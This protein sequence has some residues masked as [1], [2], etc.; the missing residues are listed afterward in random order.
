MVKV[1]ES[2]LVLSPPEP[3]WPTIQAIREKHDR[4]FSRWMPHITLLYPFYP[5]SHFESA[6]EMLADACQQVHPFEVSFSEFQAFQHGRNG[7]TLWLEPHPKRAVC[8][9]QDAL[10][11]VLPDCDETR[12]HPE[13][14]TPHLSVGQV[15]STTERDQ[16]L[17]ELRTNWE[18]LVF[19]A[20]WVDLIWRNPKPGDAFRVAVSV[21]LGTG[22]IQRTIT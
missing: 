9:L 18:T 17:S 14:F 19:R 12:K 4:N 2:A 7:F 21:A 16:I 11:Q 1:H 3:A 5:R 20:E 13:G 10:W 6:S 22:E 15:R 8:D